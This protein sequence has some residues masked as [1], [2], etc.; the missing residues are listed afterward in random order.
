LQKYATTTQ[1]VVSNK[2]Y[3]FFKIKQFLLFFNKFS[4]KFNL[5]FLL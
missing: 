1:Y 2:K 3:D 4:G 5:P